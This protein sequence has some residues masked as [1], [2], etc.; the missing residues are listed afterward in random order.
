[1]LKIYFLLCVENSLIT[2]LT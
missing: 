1:M 2:V